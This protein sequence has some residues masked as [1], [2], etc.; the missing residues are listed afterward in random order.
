MSDALPRDETTQECAIEVK[1]V[2]QTCRAPTQRNVKSRWRSLEH[3]E[4][5]ESTNECKV[6]LSGSQKNN[7]FARYS[8]EVPTKKRRTEQAGKSGKVENLES[9]AT[10]KDL[11]EEGKAETRQCDTSKL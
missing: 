3:S 9:A 11:L 7:Q 2:S 6:G 8:T 10:K 5:N 1:V 4:G